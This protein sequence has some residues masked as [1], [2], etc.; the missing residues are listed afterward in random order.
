MP[1][2]EHKNKHVIR[3][4]QSKGWTELSADLSTGRFTIPYTSEEN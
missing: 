4:N 3:W 1:A 2:T